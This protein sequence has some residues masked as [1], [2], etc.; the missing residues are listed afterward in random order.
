MTKLPEAT[1]MMITAQGIFLEVLH[2]LVAEGI[3]SEAAAV[4][5]YEAALKK[6][7]SWR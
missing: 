7:G 4:K 6:Y 3:V 1:G 5:S 2:L